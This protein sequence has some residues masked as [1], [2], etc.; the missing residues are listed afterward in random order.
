[1]KRRSSDHTL[2]MRLNAN[3]LKLAH[4]LE[5]S[6]LA[7]YADLVQH[8][9]RMVWVNF[10]AGLARGVGLFLGAGVMGA[11]TFALVTWAVYYLLKVAD[12]IPVL[13][14]LAQ[15]ARDFVQQLL[16]EHPQK[17]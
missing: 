2:L 17:S 13:G 7:S 14:H 10:T 3:V 1:M 6:N 11:L 12:M 5:A 15:I 8:P 16:R 9:W 4:R